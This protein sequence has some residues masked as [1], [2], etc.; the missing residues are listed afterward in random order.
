MVSPNMIVSSL[1]EIAIL[2]LIQ[3][4]YTSLLLDLDDTVV[5]HHTNQVSLQKIQWLEQAKSFGLHTWALSNNSSQYRVSKI[6]TQLGI[7]GLYFAM[8]PLPFSA[9]EL[10]QDHHIDPKNCLVIGDK[11]FTD[12]FLGN[13]LGAFTILVEPLTKKVS[14]ATTLRRNIELF[15]VERLAWKS[16]S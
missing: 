15:V 8:K 12:I 13:W 3:K 14:L 7:Q 10:L 16:S 1:E 11:L 4:G 2:P 6:C 5:P 9:K